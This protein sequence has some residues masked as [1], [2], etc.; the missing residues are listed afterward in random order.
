M[1]PPE[2]EP[3]VWTTYL[4]TATHAPSTRGAPP[5][6]PT[7]AWSFDVGRSA[8]GA[9]ALGDSVVAVQGRDRRLVLLDRATGHRVWEVRLGEV[10]ATGPMFAGRHV[11]AASE[12]ADGRVYAFRFNDG[13]RAWRQEVGP[14]A[15]P[16]AVGSSHVFAATRYGD[17]V[18]LEAATGR[19]SW[20]RRLPSA[21]RTGVVIAGS[22]VLVGTDDTLYALA[23]DGVVAATR[24]LPGALITPPAVHAGFV[25]V[26]SPD[27][28]VLGYDAETLEEQWRVTTDG[29]VLGAPAV[30]RDTAFAVT[31]SGTLVAIPL[32]EPAT[33]HRIALEAAVRAPSAPV[34]EGVLIATVA[35][36]VVW[37]RAGQ[38][39]TGWRIE[40]P[41]PLEHPPL[42]DRGEL[43]IMDGR[44]RL[45]VF[46]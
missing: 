35:G 29:P 1:P 43:F 30:A 7:L 15:G 25:I 14:V 20:R 6:L 27:G 33:A 18:A 26:A 4:G 5:V 19:V 45:H 24:P 2:H 36:H 21:A 13:R 44:G 41:G 23:D 3:R 34:A 17:V 40:V 10:G 8:A 12:T 11:Y 37:V 46:R 32:R 9:I 31:L 42:V 22:R 16:I 39:D 28:W 38:R